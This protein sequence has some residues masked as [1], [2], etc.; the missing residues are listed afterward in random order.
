MSTTRI[1]SLV[2]SP[3]LCCI[4]HPYKYTVTVTHCRFFR[5]MVAFSHGIW[6]PNVSPKP[7]FV[8]RKFAWLFVSA[9]KYKIQIHQKLGLLH[10]SWDPPILASSNAGRL[11]HLAQAVCTR[12]FEHTPC[13]FLIG[14]LAR[15]CGSSS[16]SGEVAHK[17]LQLVM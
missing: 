15:E 9:A 11:L 4:W 13:P 14:Y 17:V 8:E 16:C 7:I 10:G 3:G 1:T 5:L 6:A 12:L 2:A